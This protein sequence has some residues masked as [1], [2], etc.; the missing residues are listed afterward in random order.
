MAH[1]RGPAAP[2]RRRAARQPQQTV[3]RRPSAHGSPAHRSPARPSG[4]GGDAII[5][6]GGVAALVVAATGLGLPLPGGRW[7]L[8]VLLV[9]I[10]FQLARGVGRRLGRPGW[11]RRFWLSVVAGL[12]APLV[13][14]VALVAA[15]GQ[16][17]RGLTEPELRAVLGAVTMTLNL[18]AIHG[19]AR[20]GGLDH[21]W[22]IAVVAHFAVLVPVLVNGARR[23]IGPE[24]R[25]SALAGLAAG[26]AICRLLFAATGAASD[27]AIA[28]ATPTRLDGLLIGAAIAVAPVPVLR[29]LDLGRYTPAA[30]VWLVLVLLV[31][32][33]PAELGGIAAAWLA[34]VAIVPAAVLVTVESTGGDYGALTVILDNQVTRWLGRRA[35]G[36]VIW[37]GVF[38][39]ALQAAPEGGQAL[40]DW[41]GPVAF[42]AR[43]VFTLAAAA[44]SHRY[45]ESPALAAAARIADRGAGAS[46]TPLASG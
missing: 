7:A 8:E 29:R 6:L 17:Q 30:F 37:Y 38:G 21:L 42:T 16:W 35:L 14:A 34:L 11:L 43:L 36:I 40:G 10:G 18:L 9:S 24:Q 20:L 32:P 39:A 12:G 25:A 23:A 1:P 15:H 41:P 2:Q 5:G 13:V 46:R 27:Q 3:P 33:D 22:V 4:K 31:V 19:G 44:T 28:I 45:L 26:V